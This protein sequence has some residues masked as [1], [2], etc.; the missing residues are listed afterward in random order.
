MTQRVPE[1]CEAPAPFIAGVARAGD[2]D[3]VVATLLIAGADDLALAAGQRAARSGRFLPMTIVLA[4]DVLDTPEAHV[5]AVTDLV[6]AIADATADGSS[7][8]TDAHDALAVCWALA[9]TFFSNGDAA[10]KIS[11]IRD[12]VE[13]QIPTPSGEA[14]PTIDSDDR[15]ERSSVFGPAENVPPDVRLVQA[16][17]GAG[18]AGARATDALEGYL[19]GCPE[20]PHL[21]VPLALRSGDTE[22]AAR[23]LR[24]ADPESRDARL[25]AAAFDLLHNGRPDLAY[26]DIQLVATIDETPS[27]VGV[28]LWWLAAFQ[29]GRL[30]DA[31]RAWQGILERASDV[32]APHLGAAIAEAGI[33]L[34]EDDLTD[35]GLGQIY[36]NSWREI[37]EGRREHDSGLRQTSGTWVAVAAATG[38]VADEPRVMRVFD[39]GR[40]ELQAADWD[41]AARSFAAAA[42][43]AKR[44]NQKSR[45]FTLAARAAGLSDEGARYAARYAER[46]AEFAPSDPSVW[47]LLVELYSR[48][49]LEQ[50]VEEAALR[51]TEV[52]T[53]AAQQDSSGDGA[54]LVRA[55]EAFAVA[56]GDDDAGMRLLEGAVASAPK[57]PALHTA[58]AEHHLRRS[59]WAEAAGCL[60]AAARQIHEPPKRAALY[61]RIGE[62][63]LGRLG[64]PV[65]ALESFLV[66]F[67]CN[68]DVTTTLSRLEEIYISLDRY[69]DLV[70]TYDIALD[71]ARTNGS[72][73]L[74]I[75]DLLLRKAQILFERLDRPEEA[76]TA[77]IEAIRIRPTE[78]HYLTLLL[79]SIGPHVDP[80]VSREAI[81]L[82]LEALTDDPD[83]RERAQRELAPYMH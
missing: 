20:Y 10:K 57:A 42:Q 27:P 32:L 24:E 50:R 31:S 60:E 39:R 29:T 22:L 36:D 64:Q 21:A 5:G 61:S 14:S 69:R 34:G 49:G 55:S 59:E 67:V 47:T 12:R 28:W 26:A 37:I 13:N 80:A 52:L 11:R 58:L 70:G 45:L 79:E 41:A 51:L 63:Y 16:L 76:A 66:S 25:H 62:I 15:P 40:A 77:L 56:I 7:E 48:V 68:T 35:I 71:H 17:R 44:T 30:S 73:Q 23:L 4:A 83:Q 54:L 78:S 65:P 8:R 38:D 81:A 9:D 82:H 74:D 3:R 46:A 72:E 2:V 18:R 1:I 53:A 33:A 6:E 19:D 75:E 43:M